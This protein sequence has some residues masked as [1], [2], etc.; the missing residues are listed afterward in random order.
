MQDKLLVMELV[1]SLNTSLTVG[2]DEMPAPLTSLLGV[3]I[4]RTYQT[5]V[6]RLFEA[7]SS[8]DSIVN[9]WTILQ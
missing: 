3:D 1:M 8:T 5:E 7:V 4:D 6:H 2:K 9:R